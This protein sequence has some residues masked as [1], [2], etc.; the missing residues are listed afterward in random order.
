M[1]INYLIALFTGIGLSAHAGTFN[2]N[3]TGQFNA[4]GSWVLTGGSDTDGIPDADDDV[5]VLTGHVIT[6]SSVSSSNSI[7]RSI[8]INSGGTLTVSSP[9]TLTIWGNYQNDGTEL[10]N[11]SIIYKPAAAATISGTGAFSATLG[12]TFAPGAN[13]TINSGTTINKSSSTFSVQSSIV[14]N[15]GTMT[16]NSAACSGT[17]L[18][19]NGNGGAL[20]LKSG[21]AFSGG[22]LDASTVNNTVTLSYYSVFLV[23]PLGGVYHHLTI[24]GGLG[25]LKLS[26]N[27]TVNGNF[28]IAG[29]S[30]F[31]QN[32]FTLSVKGNF[33]KN[34]IFTHST[35]GE[36][37]LNGTTAQNILIAGSAAV[38]FGQLRID[39]AAGVTL[40]T[41]SYLIEHS[42]SVTSGNLNL[43]NRPVTLKSDAANTAII[44][45]CGATA[46]FSGGNIAFQRFISSR[47]AGYSDMAGSLVGQL[48]TDW[49]DDLLLI[50]SYSAPDYLPSVYGY[51]ETAFDYVPVTSS[52]QPLDPGVG[53]MVYLDSDGSHTTFNNTT[54]T[55]TGLPTI[56]D[57]DMSGYVT[58][59]NDGWNLVGNPYHAN[60][61]WDALHATTTDISPDFMSYDETVDDFITISGGSGALLAPE[62]GFWVN[63]TGGAPNLVFSETIK[64]TSNSST[65][66]NKKNEMFALRLRNIGQTSFT[67]GTSFRFSNAPESITIGGNLPFKKVPH[68]D[69]P[70]LCSKSLDGKDLKINLLNS[71]KDALMVPLKFNVGLSGIYTIESEFIDA[72]RAEGYSC[73]S[74]IDNKLNKTIDISNETYQFS[75]EKGEDDSRFTLLLT[76]SGNCQANGDLTIAN[77]QVDIN[78]IG[79]NTLVKLNFDTET[80]V[81]IVVTDMLGQKI[82]PSQLVKATVQDVYLPIPSDF[83]G[84]YLV[85]VNYNNKTQTRKLFK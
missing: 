39:N 32:N 50:Y 68:P 14:T 56:G 59:N 80:T 47:N 16:L 35:N 2:S 18:F 85:N 66:R 54:I 72:A 82:T 67:S 23:T 78:R 62:Q 26:G 43:N 64:S 41:G 19:V 81:S 40:S 6:V 1:K 70:A 57:V 73:I 11:G 7:V 29:G 63:V 24:G 21:A 42:L 49:D 30:G 76:K 61:D 53:Y 10:G 77:N 84:I 74:L 25:V 55:Q 9:R 22:K 46:S 17:G 71:S 75:A 52:S 48:L 45:T 33:T 44:G 20:T 79:E 4:A 13:R 65:F 36:I 15:L 31:N 28:L 3:A 58:F 51:D 37:L 12:Y 5:T 38:T 69:A 60:I 27:L 8:T 83:R 34:G